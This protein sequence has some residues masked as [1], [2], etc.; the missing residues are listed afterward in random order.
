[1]KKKALM[2]AVVVVVIVVAILSIENS[3]NGSVVGTW[4]VSGYEYDGVYY[5]SSDVLELCELRGYSLLDWSE[6]TLKFAKSGKVY[7]NRKE[8]GKDFEFTGNYTVGDSFIELSSEDGDDGKLVDYDGKKIYY[9]IPSQIT[10]I[11]S[12]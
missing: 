4:K 7:L 2:I 10:L 9:T 11:F 5:D 12:K 8:D 6:A 3:G 1:M